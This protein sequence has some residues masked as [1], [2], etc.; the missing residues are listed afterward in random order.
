M[1][2]LHD[3]FDDQGGGDHNCLGCNFADTTIWV[4][5]YLSRSETFESVDEAYTVACVKLRTFVL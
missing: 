2:S 1:C 3:C 4:K 5:K